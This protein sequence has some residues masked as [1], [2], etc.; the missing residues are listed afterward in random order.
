MTGNSSLAPFRPDSFAGAVSAFEGI[1]EACALVNSPLGC[2][3][4]TAYLI[5]WQDPQ[6]S[7]GLPSLSEYF[8][9]WYRAPSSY[10]DE[11]SYIM[12]S[13]EEL[14]DALR[15]IGSKDYQLVGVINSSGTTLIGE[16]LK[17]IIRSSGVRVRTVTIG[18]TAFNG[19][20]ADGF[21]VA[22]I[23]ILRAVAKRGEKIPRSVNI[24]GP[25]IFQ[26]GW[27]NNVDEL[28]RMLRVIGAEVLSVICAGENLGNLERAGQAELNVVVCEEYGDTIAAYLEKEFGT[29][30]MGINEPAPIGLSGSELW[31]KTIAD[32]LGLPKEPVEAEAKKV[33]RRC[34]HALERVSRYSGKPKGMT[35]GIFGDSSQVAPAMAFLHQYLGMYPAVLGIREAGKTSRAFIN[36]YIAKN[37]MDTTVLMDPDQ[38]IVKEH[39][40]ERRPDIVLGSSIEEYIVNGLDQK[41]AFAPFSFPYNKKIILT[42][43]PTLG[44]NGALTL[45]EDVLNAL[46][47]RI[48]E[49]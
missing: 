6:P 23:E 41:T 5:D 1:R 42:A 15:F 11:Q 21:K 24:I 4:Y 34:C 36:D 12:G 39:L 17:R 27:E 26:Y 18:S 47:Q 9:G 28:K 31:V 22:A 49:P 7:A 20:F 48:L 3:T 30:L 25:N 14:V 43:R 2:R 46:K 40:I 19:T 33:K 16:D 44:F 13:E 37:S 32:R 8:F 38:Y 29:P 45:L 10:L 35:F